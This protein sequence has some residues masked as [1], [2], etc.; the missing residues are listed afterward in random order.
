MK[1]K[2]ISKNFV[3]LRGEAEKR[4]DE[5]LWRLQE[6][7]VEDCRRLVHEL[8]NRQIELEA[9]NEE[10]NRVHSEQRLS[11][12]IDSLPDATFVNDRDGRVIAWNRAIEDMTGVRAGDILGKGDYEYSLPLYGSRRPILIDLVFQPDEQ[13][14]KEY[15]FV[16]H[17]RG[18]LCAE[19]RASLR[20]GNRMLWAI[21]GPLCDSDGNIAGA[22]ESIRDI[23]ER[24]KDEEKLKDSREQLWLDFSKFQDL[25][26]F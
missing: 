8:R 1:K 21:A 3:D 16:T 24:K 4:L 14:E 25:T 15:S 10:L 23:T 18:C 11:D 19:V 2:S 13:I 7:S 12:I 22:I 6:L 20:L 17:Q 26:I 5:Q 9:R